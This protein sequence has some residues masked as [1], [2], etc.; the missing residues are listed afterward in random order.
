MI[1]FFDSD[2]RVV[3]KVVSDFEL[4]VGWRFLRR[5]QFDHINREVVDEIWRAFVIAFAY[6]LDLDPFIQPTTFRNHLRTITNHINILSTL[7]IDIDTKIVVN[8][9]IPDSVINPEFV[10]EQPPI[11]IYDEI[12]IFEYFTNTILEC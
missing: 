5:E 12:V 9:E 2:V 10:V 1:G 7:R 11:L 6:S 8:C 3:E 4:D